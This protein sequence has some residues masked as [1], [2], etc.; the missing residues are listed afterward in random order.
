METLKRSTKKNSANAQVSAS[1]RRRHSVSLSNPESNPRAAN[2]KQMCG[3]E[4]PSGIGN[5][6]RTI[7]AQRKM[8]I[9]RHGDISVHQHRGRSRRGTAAT[10][11]KATRVGK[12]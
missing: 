3:P 5:G 10:G 8:T 7:A 6:G 9:Q 2:S 12:E 1:R 11:Q 4:S